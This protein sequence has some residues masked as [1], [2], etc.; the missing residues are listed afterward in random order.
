MNKTWPA[1]LTALLSP[2]YSFSFL[3]YCYLGDRPMNGRGR[4][5]LGHP[6]A[7]HKR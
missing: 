4:I 3:P 5:G 7:V 6:L 1:A 2:P